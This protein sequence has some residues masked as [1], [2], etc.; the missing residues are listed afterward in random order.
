MPFM[1]LPEDVRVYCFSFCDIEDLTRLEIVCKPLRN[2]VL[3]RRVWMP[4]L[5]ALEPQ[6]IPRISPYVDVHRLSVSELKYLTISALRSR[7]AWIQP[8]AEIVSPTR[9]QEI[10]LPHKRYTGPT[11]RLIS[12]NLGLDEPLPWLAGA[13]ISPM[14]DL[15][16]VPLPIGNRHEYVVLRRQP[17]YLQIVEISSGKCVWECA[18]SDVPVIAFDVDADYVEGAKVFRLLTVSS[19]R[20]GP[21]N[22]CVVKVHNFTHGLFGEVQA[23]ASVVTR[24]FRASFR[25]YRGRAVAYLEGDFIVISDYEMIWLINWRLDRCIKFNVVSDITLV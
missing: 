24:N 7:E 3:S 13:S 4:R 15:I 21:L 11:P 12:Q 1:N 6:S 18:M 20:I 17:F 10:D 8:G 14:I 5:L 19:A 22:M 23:D 2:I 9:Y 16:P 25:L